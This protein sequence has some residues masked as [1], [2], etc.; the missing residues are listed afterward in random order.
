MCF[1]KESHIFILTELEDAGK[2]GSAGGSPLQ[3]AL[4]PLLQ[5]QKEQIDKLS[6]LQGQ[7]VVLQRSLRQQQEIGL[8]QTNRDWIL[9][10]ILFA[11]QGILFWLFK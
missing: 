8:L 3:K 2:V 10:A 11:F 9:L 5:A 1:L 7:L 4:Q 6:A